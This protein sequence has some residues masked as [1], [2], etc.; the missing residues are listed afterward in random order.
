MRC[1]VGPI[2]G[3][4]WSGGVLL[5]LASSDVFFMLVCN[6]FIITM[7]FLLFRWRA[8]V[9]RLERCDVHGFGC[10]NHSKEKIEK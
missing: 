2:E 5:I 6:E 9:I 10:V 3:L 7:I 1:A 4:C 8:D